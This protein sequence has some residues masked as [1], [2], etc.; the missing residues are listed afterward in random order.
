MKVTPN[1]LKREDII[2][3]STIYAV[4]IVV[5]TGLATFFILSSQEFINSFINFQTQIIVIA[6]FILTVALFVQFRQTSESASNAGLHLELENTHRE[7]SEKNQE[8]T[9][10][11]KKIEEDLQTA[12]MVQQAL[13]NKLKPLHTPFKMAAKTVPATS[14]GGDFYQFME[15]K[16]Q[17]G[18]VDV[19]VGDVAGHGVPASLITVLSMVLLSELAKEE[20][21]PAEILNRANDLI[22]GYIQTTSVP[23]VTAFYGRYNPATREFAYARAGHPPALLLRDGQWQE[24]DAR[25]IFLGTFKDS[26]YESKSIQLLEKDILVLYSDGLTE[27]RNDVGNMY[28]TSRLEQAISACANLDPEA[29]LESVFKDNALFLAGL[30]PHDDQT[31]VILSPLSI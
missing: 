19:I 21:G 5:L 9:D 10:K 8:I 16:N 2:K 23:F 27:A 26:H 4:T 7:L 6:G 28:G 13:I 25:G 12:L 29:I 15:P 30:L 3:H 20:T 11:Q 18:C 31:L 24:L 17:G 14:I 22:E 1:F